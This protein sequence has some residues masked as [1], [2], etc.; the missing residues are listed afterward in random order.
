MTAIAAGLDHLLIGVEDLEA[1]RQ[2]YERL[3]FRTTPRGRHIGWGT[4]NYC[5]MFANDY[6]ELLG[7][8]DPAQFTN[9]LD[10]FLADK[11]EGLLGA[12]FV[13]EDLDRAA[14]ALAEKGVKT[15]GPQQLKR[16][17]ELPDGDVLPEFRL[18]HLPPET[19]P[20]LRAFLCRHLTP[21]LVWQPQWLDHPNGATHVAGLTVVVDD[22]GTLARAYADLFGAEAVKTTD[23]LF[24]ATCGLCRLR[25]TDPDGLAA[26]HAQANTPRTSTPQRGPVAMEIAVR[27]LARTADVL[28]SAGVP[29][30]TGRDGRLHLAAEEACGVVVDFV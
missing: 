13:G 5:I 12:A 1:A 17:L 11:G 18:L 19:T 15:D 22:P 28:H 26:L 27:D 30:E 25:F 16:T 24:K 7:I 6:L 9:N 8:V 2:R 10:T 29:F 23:R 20:G 21:E 14:A 3:G 4:A